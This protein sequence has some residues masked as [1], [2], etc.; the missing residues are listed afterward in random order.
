MRNIYL[1][2]IDIGTSSTKTAIIDQNGRLISLATKEYSFQ[3]P[4]PGWAEQ[5]PENWFAAAIHTIGSALHI[6]DVDSECVAGVGITGL[7]HGPVF[8]NSKG[9]SLRP[10][11][12]WADQRS[13]RE[14]EQIYRS[15]SKEGIARLTGNPVPTGFLLPTW[16]WLSKNEPDTQKR[17]QKLLLPKDYL[18]FRFTGEIGTEHSDASATSLYDPFECQWS[19]EVLNTF[20]LDANLL[21]RIYP[22]QQVAGGL[23]SRIAKTTTLKSGTPVV[24]GGSDQVCQAIGNGIIHP[25]LVSTT[26]GTGGQLFSVIKVPKYDPQLRIHLFRHAIPDTWH[27]LAATLTAGKSLQ[28]LRDNVFP[29]SNYQELANEAS[30]VSPGAEGLIF[31]P[32]LAGERTPHMDPNA[33]GCFIGLDLRHTRAHIIRGVLEGVVMSLNQG[34]EIFQALGI[35]GKKIIASGGATQHPLWLQLQADIFNRPI[36]QTQTR[37][38]AAVGAALLAGVGSGIYNNIDE[39]CRVAVQWKNCIAEPNQRFQAIYN[40]KYQLFKSL[41]P[42]IKDSSS[43]E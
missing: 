36:Y 20:S 34:L 22:S 35:K 6:N 30:Q 5:D 31:L 19:Q 15:L 16:L 24:F 42:K 17:I 18:R 33:K 7:M 26:I 9:K 27:V 37:E 21:P 43:G 23:L 1:L 2:G 29:G 38:A 10:S 11:I 14:V 8:I 28:W 13:K 3:I 12:I 25:D 39:A 41:Y 4:R 40:E 32:H